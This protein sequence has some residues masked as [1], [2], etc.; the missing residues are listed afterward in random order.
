MSDR[1]QPKHAPL[2]GS[3]IWEVA[4]GYFDSRFRLLG[5]LDELAPAPAF[6]HDVSKGSSG[7]VIGE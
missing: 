2:I 6:F 4:H 1:N 5:K 3:G 7:L